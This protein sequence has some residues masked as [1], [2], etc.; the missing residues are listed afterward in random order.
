[1]TKTKRLLI[2][3]QS[4]DADDPILGFFLRWIHV[5]ASQVDEVVVICLRTGNYRVPSNVTVYSLG[6]EQGKGRFYHIFQF[7]R[8]IIAKRTGY[9]HVFVHMNPEYVILGGWLWRWWGKKVLLWY[10][11]KAVNLRLRLAEKLT[12]TIFTAS[13]ESFRL[14]SKKVVVVGHGIDMAAALPMMPRVGGRLSLL[15]VG[16]ISPVKDLETAILACHILRNK[17]HD[18]SLDIVGG[19]GKPADKEYL[20]TLQELVVRLDMA[21]TIHFLGS[22]VHAE[23]PA[24]Y[25]SHHALV[26]T[27]N[28]GSMDKVVLEALA[29]GMPVCSSSEAFRS[30]AGLVIPC[31]PHDQEAF[32]TTIEQ[33]LHSGILGPLPQAQ[34]YVE[35]HHSLDRLVTKILAYFW[36]V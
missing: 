12:T 32:A 22:R 9:D 30:L 36:P 26:H 27:S 13:R 4:V 19:V 24:L 20:R 10:T 7:Y 8:F 18:V 2:C 15:W 3:T 16:R 1:M 34:A 21:R 29:S 35:K 28:T 23:L 6:K 11:H 33:F 5:I 14:S 17:G 31:V 25:A